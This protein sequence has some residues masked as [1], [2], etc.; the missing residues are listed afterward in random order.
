MDQPMGHPNSVGIWLLAQGARDFVT[1]LLSGEGADEVFGGYTRFYYASLQSTVAPWAPVLSAIPGVGHRIGR[2]FRGNAADSFSMASL[3]E[4]PDGL[5]ALRPVANFETGLE[6][7]RAFFD[8]GRSEH[9][10]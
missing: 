2:Q 7:R 3:F 4:Q 9:L 6:R 1:V 10:D 8:E 5:R